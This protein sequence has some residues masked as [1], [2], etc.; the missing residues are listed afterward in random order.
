MKTFPTSEAFPLMHV[1]EY[2]ALRNVQPHLDIAAFH[3]Y[4]QSQ[5]VLRSVS[6]V[7]KQMDAVAR[8]YLYRAACTTW[9]SWPTFFAPLMRSTLLAS[10]SSVWYSRFR[11]PW[12]MRNTES[13]TLLSLHHTQT[14]PTSTMWRPKPQM[15][16]DTND[17]WSAYGYCVLKATSA[18]PSLSKNG[19]G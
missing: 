18:S 8:R 15:S 17:I 3:A 19:P 7:S 14:T 6:L 1:F 4:K 16:L 5:N 2:L 12:K 11:S 13:L 10:T 9:T